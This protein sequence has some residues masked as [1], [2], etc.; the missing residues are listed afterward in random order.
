MSLIGGFLLCPKRRKKSIR[1]RRRSFHLPSVHE[2]VSDARRR[3]RRCCTGSP[4]RSQTRP[5]RRR[6][7][8]TVPGGCRRTAAPDRRSRAPAGRIWCCAVPLTAAAVV[9]SRVSPG[10]SGLGWNPGGAAALPT[11][12]RFRTRR[13][14]IFLSRLLPGLD[15]RRPSVL[16]RKV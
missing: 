8:G 12:L 4:S 5:C 11:R 13:P 2:E 7:R 16:D 1:I 14:R 10:R 15:D 3:G 6:R 9:G